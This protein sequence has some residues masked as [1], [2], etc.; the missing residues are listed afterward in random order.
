MSTWITIAATDLNDYLVAEQ[1]DALRTAA[2]AVGQADPFGA[3]APDVIRKVRAY[4]ASNGSNQLS[5]GAL[6]IP[7]E[8]KLDVC[9]LIIDPMLGRLNIALTKDQER[10]VEGANETLKLIASGKL[11]VSKPDDAVKPT[12]QGGPAVQTASAAT[13]RATRETMKG[14]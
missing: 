14:L 6:S 1:V 12:V 3:V 10:A 2:L 7:P 8:L 5:S 13:R 11:K 9:Y 4:I